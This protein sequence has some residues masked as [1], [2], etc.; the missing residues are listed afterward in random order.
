[1]PTV[2]TWQS[3]SYVEVPMPDKDLACESIYPQRDGSLDISLV[4]G[5]STYAFRVPSDYVNFN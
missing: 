3:P 4:D 2:T 1:M 5:H